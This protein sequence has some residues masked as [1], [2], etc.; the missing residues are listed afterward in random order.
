MDR[1]EPAELDAI[2]AAAEKPPTWP[3]VGIVSVIKKQ[4]HGAVDYLGEVEDFSVYGVHDNGLN[5]VVAL[6]HLPKKKALVAEIA[7]LA[8]FVDYHFPASIIDKINPRLHLGHAVIEG[9]DLYL[10]AKIAAKGRFRSGSFSVMIDTWRHD[11]LV[12]LKVVN[13][14]HANRAGRPITSARATPLVA[15]AD[16]GVPGVI[17]ASLA[18]SCR[19]CLGSGRTR[20]LKRPCGACGGDG[21]EREP[22]AA[23]PTGH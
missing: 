4:F 5:F 16:G 6:Y 11:L 14:A 17:R 22:A 15:G 23:R 3:A 9:E 20:L 12:T 1:L 8:S 21:L 10:A 13:E 19:P 7:L 18:K 2:F